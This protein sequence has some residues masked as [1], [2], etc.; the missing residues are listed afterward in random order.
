MGTDV[1]RVYS[2]YSQGT[3][4]STGNKTDLAISD[5]NNSFFTIDFPTDTGDETRYTRDGSFSLNAD[6]ELVTAEGYKVMGENGPIILANSKDFIVNNYGEI[7]QN[8]EIVDRL[9]IT[10]FKDT[11]AL[12]KIGDNLV[13]VEGDPEKAEFSG[14]IQQG[15]LESSNVNSVREMVNIINVTRAYEANQKVFQAQDE[16]LEKAVNQVGSV[17]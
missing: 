10:T 14:K 12:R 6:G 15:F 1:G 9:Q 11:D 2:D 4:T 16:T 5:S 8:G 7:L 17:K 13:A 3:I